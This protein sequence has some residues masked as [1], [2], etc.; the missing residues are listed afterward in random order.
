MVNTAN[1]NKSFKTKTPETRM[2]PEKD[3]DAQDPKVL[4]IETV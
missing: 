2:D 3:V 1:N 4:R